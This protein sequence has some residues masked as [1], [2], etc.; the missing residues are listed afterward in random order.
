[1]AG[2]GAGRVA[3]SAGRVPSAAGTASGNR[4]ATAA[5][6]SESWRTVPHFSVGRDVPADGLLEAVAAAKA[7]GTAVTI[8]DFFSMA[9]ARA[10]GSVGEA[11]T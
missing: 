3:G 7:G 9:L 5:R 1:M 10:L 8:T 4:Q 2:T 11:P 6:V